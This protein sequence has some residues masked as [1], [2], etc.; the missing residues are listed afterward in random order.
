VTDI[1]IN[2][3]NADCCVGLVLS[4]VRALAFSMIE[5]KKFSNMRFKFVARRDC[6]LQAA[7]KIG[8][9]LRFCTRDAFQNYNSDN[10]LHDCDIP[11]AEENED[12]N[13]NDND[14]DDSMQQEQDSTTT[15]TTGSTKIKKNC[16]IK[17]TDV[18]FSADDQTMISQ[19][20]ECGQHI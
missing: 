7:P 16:Q 4:S 11:F 9:D 15:S 13:D 12:D 6:N 14:N 20:E 17:L 1:S 3:A 19:M 5:M 2:P 10:D 8:V 18:T